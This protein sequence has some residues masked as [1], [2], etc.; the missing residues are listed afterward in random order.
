MMENL[1]FVLYSLFFAIGI[2]QF[3]EW[4]EHFQHLYC[5]IS[6]TEFSVIYNVKYTK[7]HKD[8]PY[9]IVYVF[10][11]GSKNEFIVKNLPLMDFPPI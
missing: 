5:D 6:Q 3:Q 1:T 2:K 9:F 10:V 11:M 8:T 4:G 7:F